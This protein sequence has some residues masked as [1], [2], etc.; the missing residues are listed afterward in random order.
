MGDAAEGVEE[1]LFVA[2]VDGAQ[3]DQARP[4]GDVGDDPVGA[5]GGSPVVREGDRHTREHD[6]RGA[7][8]ADRGVARPSSSSGGQPMRMELP[9]PRKMT[10]RSGLT[11]Y[12]RSSSR[13]PTRMPTTCL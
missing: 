2:G 6:A 5:Q 7:A 8:T 4:S 1:A 9:M 3:V 13:N 12:L 11:S 10:K